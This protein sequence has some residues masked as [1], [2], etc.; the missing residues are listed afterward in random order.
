MMEVGGSGRVRD[1][2]TGQGYGQVKLEKQR[3]TERLR[4]SDIVLGKV[5][6]QNKVG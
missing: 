4:S 3:Q 1:T 5:S 6:T 2:E